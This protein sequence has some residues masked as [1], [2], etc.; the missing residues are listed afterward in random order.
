MS[1]SEIK[2][3]DGFGFIKF[4]D[5]DFSHVKFETKKIA[6]ENKMIHWGEKEKIQIWELTFITF[7][8]LHIGR[9]KLTGFWIKWI[10]SFNK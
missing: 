10:V 4:L 5:L 7:K 8:S 3:D 9:E 2:I 1:N 6:G